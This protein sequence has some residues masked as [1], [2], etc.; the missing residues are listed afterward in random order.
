[1]GTRHGAE[2]ETAPNGG[3]MSEWSRGPRGLFSSRA[4]PRR[5]T[6]FRSGVFGLPPKGVG[7]LIGREGR[8]RRGKRAAKSGT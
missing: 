2:S 7:T 8:L 6:R 3:P 5:A 1:M 4:S